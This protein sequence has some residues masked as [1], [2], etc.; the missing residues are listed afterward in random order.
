[1]AENFESI[2]KSLLSKYLE[3]EKALGEITDFKICEIEC[4][5]PSMLISYKENGTP[6]EIVMNEPTGKMVLAKW[7]FCSQLLTVCPPFPSNIEP[8]HVDE[9]RSVE[10]SFGVRY[11]A[12]E[13]IF[14]SPLDRKSQFESFEIELQE[15]KSRLLTFCQ[16]YGVKKDCLHIR[17][18]DEEVFVIINADKLHMPKLM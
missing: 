9:S 7:F 18:S 17:C 14:P 15:I 12:F 10:V 11:T 2:D 5:G 3:I 4:C 13:N 8:Y 6:Q 1:M 16:K